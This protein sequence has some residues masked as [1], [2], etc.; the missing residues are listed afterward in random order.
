MVCEI[1][2][3][4]VFQP[5]VFD[6]LSRGHREA[7]RWGPLVEGDL[8]DREGLVTALQTHNVSAVLPFAA[9]VYFGESVA[10]PALYYRNNLAGTLALLEA[11]RAA[12]VDKIVF[13]ST[14][15]TYGNPDS[16]P[17]R[18]DAPQHPVNPYGE[19]KLAIERALRWYGDAYHLRSVSLPYFNAAGADSE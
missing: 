9:Y 7:V 13:S 2:P 14:C 3:Q 6:N 1:L 15:A 18:E 17:I 8:A 11:M 19:T 4:A 5:V 12:G 16:V 10:D